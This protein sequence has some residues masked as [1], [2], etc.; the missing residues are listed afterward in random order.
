MTDQEKENLVS[1]YKQEL[2]QLNIRMAQEGYARSEKALQQIAENRVAE[3]KQM[4][5]QLEGNQDAD[6][7][8]Q[9]AE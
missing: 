5:A 2:H 3:L 8:N 7:T 4:I 1:L 6:Q 9:T